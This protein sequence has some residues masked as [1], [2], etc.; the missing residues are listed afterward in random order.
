MSK[1]DLRQVYDV[2]CSL[3]ISSWLMVGILI[4]DDI[5]RARYSGGSEKPDCK[6]RGGIK[7]LDCGICLR[8]ESPSSS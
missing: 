7:D 2:G 4:K 5:D 8:W 1:E 6:E 3:V